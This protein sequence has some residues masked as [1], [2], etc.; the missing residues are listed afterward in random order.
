MLVRSG[1]P[2]V[3]SLKIIVKSTGNSRLREIITDIY[4]NVEQGNKFSD[5]L[6]KYS[7]VFESIHI[8]LIKVAESTGKLPETLMDIFEYES[9][10][11]ASIDKI[12][13][14]IVYPMTILILGFG[15]LGFLLSFVVP[16]MEKIFSSMNKELPLSTKVLISIGNFLRFHGYIV[17]IVLACIFVVFKVLYSYNKKFRTVIDRFLLGIG[18]IKDITISKLA[19]N[20][21]FQLNEG[22][23][24]VSSLKATSNT[25]NNIILK[26][27]LNRISE[28]VSTGK[29]FSDSVKKADIFPELFVAAV[30]TGEKSGNLAEFLNRISEFYSKQFEKVT[31]RFISLIEP[32]FIVFI[33]LIVG[34]IVTSIMGPLFEINTFIK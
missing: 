7:N 14:A 19:H 4:N 30:A 10:K 27:H 11:K 17:L 16:K 29:K 31:S 24:L 34:F 21:S 32:V 22:L 33:G 12:K 20:L 9:E 26:E 1:I 13:S 2:L 8:N 5:S 15:V 6:D 3:N 23:T 28:E 18:F 25:L